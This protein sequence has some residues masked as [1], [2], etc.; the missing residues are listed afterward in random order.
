MANLIKNQCNQD[1]QF[2]GN[3]E[4][5]LYNKHDCNRVTILT[6]EFMHIYRQMEIIFFFFSK[7]KILYFLFHDEIKIYIK[8]PDSFEMEII[9]IQ[10]LRWIMISFYYCWWKVG[11]SS[12]TYFV[13]HCGST[14]TWHGVMG[15]LL[16]SLPLG[17]KKTKT[18]KDHIICLVD[19]SKY[20]KD[21]QTMREN[22]FLYMINRVELEVGVAL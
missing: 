20:A 21:D 16:N 17:H 7:E 8:E 14:G 3:L 9:F 10:W 13:L 2:V 1:P 19:T 11:L 12:F 4:L 15:H 22:S 6:I 5:S 18:R